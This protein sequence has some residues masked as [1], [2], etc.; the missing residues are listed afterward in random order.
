MPRI[1]QRLITAGGAV[2]AS[3]F[4]T[5]NAFAAGIVDTLQDTGEAGFGTRTPPSLPATVG[6]II[7]TFLGVL[8]ILAVALIL[9]AGFLWMTAAGNEQKVE[10]ARSILTQ[11]V[12]G[13]AIILA[14]YAIANFV[15]RSLVNATG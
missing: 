14:S 5:T 7:S 15:V 4:L 6:K 11:A 1:F 13:L 12:I 8:G 9:Y 2:G 10:K 3:L